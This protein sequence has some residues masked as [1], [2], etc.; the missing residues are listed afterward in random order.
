MKPE[1]WHDR[2]RSG[3]IAFHQVAPDRNLVRHWSSLELPAG[4]R[5]FVPLCGKSLDLLWLREHG[6]RVAGIEI[7]EIAIEAFCAEN[8]IPAWRRILP[9]FDLYEAPGMS[10]LRGDFFELAAT[11]LGRVDALYDRAAAIALDAPQRPRYVEKLAS[12]LE[13]GTPMLLVTVEY[14]QAQIAGPPFS[15]ESDEVM[16]LYAPY[17]E[18]RE[19]GRE[20]TLAHET[21]M[22]ARGVTAWREVSYRLTRR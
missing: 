7:S 15:L 3:R 1:F 14:P 13:P 19:I 18:L 17:F 10:L 21:R 22:R 16:R 2:W 6:Q 5:V 9:K 8:G 12:L 11:D 4:S 20:D